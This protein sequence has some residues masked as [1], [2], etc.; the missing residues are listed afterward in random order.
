MAGK[1]KWPRPS[2]EEAQRHKNNGVGLAELARMYQMPKANLHRLISGEYGIT[3]P[4]VGRIAEPEQRRLELKGKGYTE[5]EVSRMVLNL[6]PVD[7]G[8]DEI[9]YCQLSLQEIAGL[10]RQ[11]NPL[12]YRRWDKQLARDLR[13]ANKLRAAT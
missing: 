5:E 11:S 9:L 12:L 7:D 10:F 3:L 6:E 4:K 1:S 8:D 13:Q 2:I